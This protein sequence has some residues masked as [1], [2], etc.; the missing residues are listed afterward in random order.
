MSEQPNPLTERYLEQ[1]AAALERTRM[2]AGESDAIRREIESHLAEAVSS[3][4]TLTEML[5]RL[6][7]AED[8]ARAYAVELALNPRPKPEASSWQRLLAVALRGAATVAS[9][10][11]VA[12]MGAVA[13]S[14]A[15]S[16]VVAVL[17]GLI[18]PFLPS[19]WMDPTL[20]AGLPQLVV[21]LMGF[22][23]LAVGV[24]SIRIVRLNARF[25]F[26]ALRRSSKEIPK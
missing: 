5:E 20:R 2:P 11:L 15:A 1:L 8:L 23:L 17:I 25:L 13:V 7:S 3:G 14:F 4:A 10:L 24:V 18:A 26:G 9:G 22:G 12:V 16:G 19:D 6:G 21:V